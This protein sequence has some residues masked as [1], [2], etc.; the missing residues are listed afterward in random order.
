MTWYIYLIKF[1]LRHDIRPVVDDMKR[2]V[3]A[4]HIKRI[5]KNIENRAYHYVDLSGNH[6]LMYLRFDLDEEKDRKFGKDNLNRHYELLYDMF[7]DDVDD[8]DYYHVYYPVIDMLDT[9]TERD[10]IIIVE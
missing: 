10:P 3:E 2:K 9:K 4:L 8:V 7:D 1:I 5:I 6:H